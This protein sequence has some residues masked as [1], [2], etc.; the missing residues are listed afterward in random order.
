MRANRTPH[1]QEWSLRRSTYGILRIEREEDA[2]HFA[3][4]TRPQA[5][6]ISR[7]SLEE[8][9]QHW[10]IGVAGLIRRALSCDHTLDGF[11]QHFRADR[12]VKV[13]GRAK[14]PGPALEAAIPL[15]R[16]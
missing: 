13:S 4:I 11:E 8:Q 1:N 5:G 12:F 2:H 7:I 3:A 6:T 15:A 14:L 10:G 16:D 9:A